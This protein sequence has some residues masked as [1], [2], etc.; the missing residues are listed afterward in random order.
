M[1]NF[2]KLSRT[3]IVLFLL[4]TFRLTSLAQ[5]DQDAIMM[6]KNNLCSG[7]MYGH[8]SWTNY[9]EGTFKR[10]N[11]NLG[12]VST[13]MLSVMG[14][15]G[16]NR[17]LNVLFGLPYVQTKASAG[18][19]HGTK[20]I[21]DISVW[22][23]WMPVEKD[24]K[25]GTVSLYVL[26]GTSLPVTN[27]VADFLPLSIGLHSK[28]LSGR[29]ILDYQRGSFFATGS[30]TYTYR[31][32]VTIDRTSYY[33][34]S[35]I[36]SNQVQMPDVMSENFRIGYRSNFIIAEAVVSNMTT[37]SGFDIRKNDMPFLSNK[38]NATTAGI[39][40]KYTLRKISALAITGSANYTVAGRNVGQSTNLNIG[41]FYVVDFN[42]KKKGKK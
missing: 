20:G 25:K 28:T 12:T 38:M 19:M 24:F 41:A 29:I 40:F 33:T 11:P 1:R 3:I 35:L 9:W 32:N 31:S 42:P 21:Q 8:S 13:N 10:D 18:T 34:T 17:R 36:L 15:Y 2:Y 23:K 22:V 39:N 16:I 6:S 27:Y 30:A 26:G 4:F 14:N 37:L 7:L 5:T